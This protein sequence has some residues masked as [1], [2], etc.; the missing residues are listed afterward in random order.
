MTPSPMAAA[1]T[2]KQMLVCCALPVLLMVPAQLQFRQYPLEELRVA[3][4]QQAELMAAIK[5][6]GDDEHREEA[7][8]GAARAA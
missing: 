6:L 8:V 2:S 4:A 5:V 3:G 7:A 1:R